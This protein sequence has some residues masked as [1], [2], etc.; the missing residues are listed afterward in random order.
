MKKLKHI[1]GFTLVE[2]LVTIAIG[3][4]IMAGMAGVVLNSKNMF[5][6]EQ[7]GASIQE[8]ARYVVETL[9]YDIRMAGS[10]DCG[11]WDGAATVVNAVDTDADMT[12]LMDLTAVVGFEGTED[13]D[14]ASFPDLFVDDADIPSDSIILR[15]AD[16]ATAVTIIDH[17]TGG[18]GVPSSFDVED[19]VHDF[20]EGEKLLVVDSG[21][22]SIA[23]FEQSSS[24]SSNILHNTGNGNPGN[25]TKFLRHSDT[26][27][28]NID[29]NSSSCSPNSCDGLT[30]VA[31][32][33]GSQVMSFIANVYYVGNSNVIPDMPA[34]KMRSLA[35]GDSETRIEELAQGVESMELLFGVDTNGDPTD[36]GPDGILDQFV[37]A[38]EVADWGEVKAVRYSIV[39]R[40]QEFVHEQAMAVTLNGN[41]Y[42][43]RY[44]RQLA[45]GVVNI[46]NR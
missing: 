26:S 24:S 6:S 22:R 17:G 5:V 36:D 10:S 18:G 14:R 39:F 7:E 43:D 2:L 28:S 32:N 37:D 4:F 46:R 9:A 42:N 40:S 16:P 35:S 27:V 11:S 33:P 3:A 25:C 34:L 29:C 41:D 15:Y 45:S 1:R 23:V 19:G 13:A 31:F 30:A 44:L 20:Q 8:N 12:E 21:C 38:D